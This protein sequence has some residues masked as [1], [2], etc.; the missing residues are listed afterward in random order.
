MQKYFDIEQNTFLNKKAFHISLAGG[1]LFFIVDLFTPLGI[2]EWLLYLILLIFYWRY[3]D[4][5][6]V[7]YLSGLYIFFILAGFLFSPSGSPIVYEIV[8]RFVLILCLLVLSHSIFRERT[9]KKINTEILDRISDFFLAL[10]A[11]LNIVYMNSSLTSKTMRRDFFGKNVFE[12]FPSLKGTL[13]EEKLSEAISTQ[14][15]V[16]FKMMSPSSPYLYQYSVYPSAKG[17]SVFTKDI[18]ALDKAEEKIRETLRE[19]EML[20]REIHH[21]VKNNF[22]IVSSLLGLSLNNIQDEGFKETV[23]VLQHRIRALALIH[24]K[25]YQSGSVSTVN[26]QS[27]VE[28][29]FKG[30]YSVSEYRLDNLTTNISV[31]NKINLQI[32]T[33]MPLGLII[34]ELYTNS[35]KHA[36]DGVKDCSIN[37]SLNYTNGNDSE[38]QMIYHDN[39]KGFTVLPDISSAET[40]GFT[41]ISS[42]VEQINGKMTVCNK[43]GAEFKI[44]F[45]V[46]E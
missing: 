41:I 19:K 9:I 35:L 30:F 34:N 23:S 28:D 36:F 24:E 42:F 25:L 15:P 6:R 46:H 13:Y 38:L 27:F 5:K 7:Y 43:G 17:L 26:I 45:K 44:N 4:L 14:K 16:Q 33:A 1:I 3:S 10:D 8:N 37:L 39:G 29:L 2:A 11:D 12:I 40:M 31:N 18:T 21:R 22:Q 32:K 20:L